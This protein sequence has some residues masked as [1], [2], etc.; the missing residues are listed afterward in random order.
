MHQPRVAFL[1]NWGP[2]FFINF[3]SLQLLFFILSYQPSLLSLFFILSHCEHGYT[4]SATPQDVISFFLLHSLLLLHLSLLFPLKWIVDHAKHKDCASAKS[5]FRSQIS[6]YSVIMQFN[7]SQ[8][9][10]F[11]DFFSFS[12]TRR[13]SF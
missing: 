2:S 1:C 12:L 11:F 4:Q 8:T 13:F 10:F 7:V 3:L 6:K 9:C 5:T